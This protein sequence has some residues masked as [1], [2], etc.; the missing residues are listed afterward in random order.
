M[1]TP[2][3][4]LTFGSVEYFAAEL[5]RHAAHWTDVR[6]HAYTLVG[7]IADGGCGRSAVDLERIR[8][9]LTAAE[10]VRAERAA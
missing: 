4:P 1:T 5:R 8:N 6:L 10:L 7:V 9:I 3:A 2:T